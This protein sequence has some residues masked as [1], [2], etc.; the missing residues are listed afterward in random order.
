MQYA[1]MVESKSSGRVPGLKT[2]Q[3]TGYKVGDYAK[4]DSFPGTVART[5]T[6]DI[7]GT[8]DD[9][10]A[11]TEINHAGNVAGVVGEIGIHGHDAIGLQFILSEVEAGDISGAKSK[12]AGSMNDEYALWVA[13]YP[14]V[15]QFAGAI[16]GIVVDNQNAEIDR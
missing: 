1:A 10:L 3:G 15:N 16:R 4:P 14:F 5:P 12:F 13:F 7:A 9:I 2:K 8:D 6:S 11:C